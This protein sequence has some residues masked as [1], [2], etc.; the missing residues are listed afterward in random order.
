MRE[1]ASQGKAFAQFYLGNMYDAGEGVPEDNA[2]A[3]KWY[4]LAADQ[5]NAFAQYNLGN[6]YYRGQGVPVNFVTAYAWLNIAAAFG[7]ESA[8]GNRQ[9]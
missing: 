3:V 4:R 9:S 6:T 5:G 8:I 7:D 2:E 1:L